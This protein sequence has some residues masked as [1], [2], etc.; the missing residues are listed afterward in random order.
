MIE[1]G[2]G[3]VLA[4]RYR[5]EYLLGEGGMGTVW[6]ATHLI[7]HK[8]VAVKLLRGEVA[9]D[10]DTLRRFVREAR[11]A[12]A[13]RHP[14]VVE[15]HDILTLDDGS[16]A[17]IMDLLEGETLAQCLERSG[18]LQLPDLASIMA[19]VLSAVGSAHAVGI[20]HR[21]L[22]PD[23]IFLA[24]L[25]DGRVEPKVLDFGIAKL[26]PLGEKMD[27]ASVGLT[28]TGAVLG[29]PFYMAPEQAFGEKD[30][31]ARVD[32]WALGVI[33]YECSSGQR[34]I[35]GESLG[36]VFKMIT[37]GPTLP[38]DRLVP[39]LPPDFVALVGRMMERDRELRIRDLREPFEFLRR[40]SGGSVQNFGAAVSI[41]PPSGLPA[42]SVPPQPR[43][44][45]AP[46]MM[47]SA[48]GASALIGT[49]APITN[50][51][52]L[53]PRQSRLIPALIGGGVV[54]LLVVAGLYVLGSRDSEPTPSATHSAVAP[55]LAPSFPVP[56]VT[57]PQPTVSALP[58]AS[59]APPAAQPSASATTSGA[60]ATPVKQPRPAASGAGHRQLPGGVHGDIP[61]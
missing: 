47:P 48:E 8:R 23:N 52:R 57:Q 16:P 38:L 13:V 44:S 1:Q 45:A 25:G 39:D 37:V 51:A 29:T 12:S 21:D 59:A 54:L 55:P 22:K 53:A 56:P 42:R 46:T 27:A 20:V 36:Q 32:V 43:D 14:N 60:K 17:M 15:I 33:L 40:W 50:G 11:A 30:V 18:P 34:P 26:M 5:L 49:G 24:R 3:S 35:D 28:R 10:P 7:T 41:F 58:T 31:D 6:A 9:S 19:P 61:F 4:G 2:K